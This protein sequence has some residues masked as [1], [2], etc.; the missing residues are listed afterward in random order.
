MTIFISTSTP[1]VN[2]RPH[3]G[4]A[5]EFVQADVLARHQRSRGRATYLLTGTDDNAAKN[6]A[7]AAAAGVP[8]AEFVARTGEVFVRLADRL[9]VGYDDVL[10]TGTDPRHRA[11]VEKLWHGVGHD[12]YRR[13]YTGLYCLGCE[14]FYQ[15]AELAAGRCPEHDTVPDEVTE[16]N[17]FFALSRYQ[18]Q[19]EQ[20]IS[21]GQVEI[22]PAH[23]RAEV[24]AFV[25]AGLNDYSVSR[26]SGR[27]DGWGIPVPGDPE[28]TIYVW[29]DALCNYISAPGYGTDADSYRD[30]WADAEARI[31]LVG[32][33]IIRFHAVFWLATL[34]SAGEPLPTR[35]A[36][37]EYL[38]A[39]GRKIS[40]SAPA[41]GLSSP[42]ELL[43]RYGRDALRWWFVSDVNRVGDTDFTE[44]RLADRYSEDLVNTIGNLINRCVTLAR[45]AYGER[46]P[47]LS[48][49]AATVVPCQT[50][51]HELITAVRAAEGLPTQIDAALAD[52]D[53]R[54]AARAITATAT[55]ANIA[56]EST[57][58]WQHLSAAADGDAEALAA[59][60][61]VLPPLIHL[62]RQLAA[63]L[64]P[65]VPDGAQRLADALGRGAGLGQPVPAFERLRHPDVS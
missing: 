30:R 38:Q 64:R 43:D 57:R 52:F 24:L 21:S 31:H 59:L 44:Q 10:H 63:E 53:L 36:V 19:L 50:R 40:K 47:Q 58:P 41:A 12:L 9:G 54:R 29:W 11:A 39:G 7:A 42:E 34:L 27:S 51:P 14:Q 62:C 2:A 18:D 6:V 35:I 1:Y 5:L 28:Q 61:P 22:Q 55:A 60:N 17:W 37:H 46:L 3:L 48:E 23:R 65:F 13:T 15:P 8:V 20:L 56:V 32:K 49:P 25:R 45:R 4:H 26:P 33:G 16:Q